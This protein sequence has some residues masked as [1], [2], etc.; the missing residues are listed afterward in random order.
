MTV[1][2][3]IL[4]GLI[5]LGGAVTLFFAFRGV[6]LRSTQASKPYGVARQEARHEMQVQFLRG[7]FLL[8]LTLILL[9]LYGLTPDQESGSAEPTAAATGTV[10]ET[11]P[12][13]TDPAQPEATGTSGAATEPVSTRPAAG[14]LATVQPSAAALTATVEPTATIA[15]LATETPDV[16]TAEV[17]SPNGLWLREAPGGTQQL[18]LIAHET[19][20]TLLPGQETAGELEWQQVRTP[21]G[22]EGWV[23]VDFLIFQ[24]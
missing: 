23:A 6:L 17:N 10:V 1:I 15:V 7:G 8:V 14:G 19:Q 4:L 18:E 3:T 20:L 21:A 13:D 16:A 11:R 9:G 5:L 12:S 24:D 22:N 2:R